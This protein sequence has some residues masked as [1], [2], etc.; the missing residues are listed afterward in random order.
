MKDFLAKLIKQGNL[1]IGEPSENIS[2]AYLEKS[3]SNFEAAKILLR[4]DKLEESVSFVYYSMYNLVLSLLYQIGIKSGNHS[5]SIFLL[6]VIF[7]FENK[8]IIEMK[9]ERIDKQYYIGFHITKREVEEEMKIAENFN[10][11][12]RAFVLGVGK[13]DIKNYR[14]KFKGMIK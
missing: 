14:D 11:E 7:N 3:V 1:K 6:K 2:K 13:N 10:R 4:N 8:D 12:L 9:K 5:A